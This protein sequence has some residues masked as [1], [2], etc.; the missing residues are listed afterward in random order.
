M[1]LKLVSN[2]H[3]Y[4]EKVFIQLK[5]TSFFVFLKNIHSTRTTPPCKRSFI[6]AGI[7]RFGS[8]TLCS[9]YCVVCA[10]A[11]LMSHRFTERT[12]FI[13]D[14][15]RSLFRHD[16]VDADALQDS[17]SFSRTYAEHHFALVKLLR[18][19]TVCGVQNTTH[20]ACF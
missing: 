20:W 2:F 16:A 11:D 18:H 9:C 10:S 8:S 14:R 3:S 1:S 5:L 6:L 15:S 19:Q 7:F 12:L 17:S 13:G 4:L